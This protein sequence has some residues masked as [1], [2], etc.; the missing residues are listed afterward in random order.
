M[1]SLTSKLEALE[2]ERQQ[3]LA[4]GAILHDCWVGRSVPGGTASANAKPHYQLRSRQAIFN[5][6]KSQ[7]LSALEVEDV[8]AQIARGRQLKKID[9]QIAI[10]L[11]AS[12]VL[13]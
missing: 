10:W 8:N 1:K 7:Y 13:R 9:K 2:T 11:N 12:I 3:L 4:G 5:G 6:R